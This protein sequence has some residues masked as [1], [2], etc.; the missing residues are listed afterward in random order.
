[1]STE[2]SGPGFSPADQ[3][4]DRV[5][6]RH[7]HREDREVGVGQLARIEPSAW[8][9]SNRSSTVSSAAWRCHGYMPRSHCRRYIAIAQ[10]SPSFPDQAIAAD[11]HVVEEHLAE[12]VAA[13]HRPDRTDGDARRVVI[14]EDHRQPAVSR[15]R[16]AG[17]NERDA[18]LRDAGLRRPDLVPADHPVVAVADCLRAQRREVAARSRA[19]RS[20]GTTPPRRA[21]ARRDTRWRDPARTPRA[22]G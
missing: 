1:M 4:P 10:P 19:R 15:L 3:A 14:D 16:R 12:L 20:P 7:P 5:A 8:S 22:S 11:V 21:A 2:T 17:A 6:R 13:G 18:S 9:A